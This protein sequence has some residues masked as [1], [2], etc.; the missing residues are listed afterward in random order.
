MQAPLRSAMTEEMEYDLI[1]PRIWYMI[2]CV[3][4]IVQMAQTMCH[5]ANDLFK[6]T[7]VILSLQVEST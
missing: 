5:T 6:C 1:D 7:C 3:C 2:Q 4:K